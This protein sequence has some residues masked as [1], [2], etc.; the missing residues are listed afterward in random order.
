MRGLATDIVRY[1]PTAEFGNQVVAVIAGHK[2][3]HKLMAEMISTCPWQEVVWVIREHDRVAKAAL[4]EIGVEYLEVGLNPWWRRREQPA[5]P[6]SLV[7][8]KETKLEDGT[9]HLTP[10]RK[11]REVFP[12]KV[13]VYDF[14]SSARMFD[15]ERGCTHI[16]TFEGKEVTC[17]ER[18]AA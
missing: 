14:R 16:L 8:H 3:D 15:F 4:D 1:T 10:L 7:T 17:T 2:A 6:P 11:P 12:K 5:G 13:D 18:I 9:V